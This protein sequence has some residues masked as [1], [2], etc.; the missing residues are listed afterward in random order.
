MPKILM[1]EMMVA[2]A[3]LGI[4]IYVRNK[5]PAEMTAYRS[6]RTVLFVHGA[7]YPSSAAFDL[8]LDGM[9]WMDY[10]ALRGYDVYL[11]DLRG[12]GKSTRP[13]EMAEDPKANPPIVNG[14]TAVK[15]ISAV[16]EFILRRRNVSKLHL[17]GWSWGATLI[18]TYGAHNPDKVERL[19][20]YGPPWVCIPQRPRPARIAAYRTL[21][22]EQVKATWYEGVPEHK[23][24]GLMPPCWFDAWIA[25]IW[26][27]DPVGAN[28]NP[29][30]IH[31]PNGVLQDI[32]EFHGAGKPYYDPTKITVPNSLFWAN[33]IAIHRLTWREP[34]SHSWSMR[35]ASTLWSLLRE[36]TILCWR[37]TV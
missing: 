23:R 5:F 7:T 14:T 6:E 25:A 18:A 31:A 32:C 22:R 36:R 24:D 29:P 34:N 9:S 21:T 19:V 1:E 33:G 8:A 30:V 35:L 28:K 2:T 13:K 20:Q 4:E 27:S 11:L 16:I 37:G 17:I 12:Y 10:I 3:D 26:A 15:D